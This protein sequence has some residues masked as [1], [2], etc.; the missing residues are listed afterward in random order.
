[1][2]ENSNPQSELSAADVA[3][4]RELTAMIVTSSLEMAGSDDSALDVYTAVRSAALGVRTD[5]MMGPDRWLTT[6]FLLGGVTAG[7]LG[8][9]A[10]LTGKS[11]AE[12]WQSRVGAV[13]SRGDSSET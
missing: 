7:L 5:D 10:A 11:S 2:S 9:L 12:I 13:A 8:E 3:W 1:M 4:A 6:M